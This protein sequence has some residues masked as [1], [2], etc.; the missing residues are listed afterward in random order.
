MVRISIADMVAATGARLLCGDASAQVHGITT[1][2]RAVEPGAVFV[3]FVGERV[4]G[5]R[6][7]AQAIEAG[8][9][10]VVLTEKPAME[11]PISPSAS[12]AAL[13]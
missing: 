4:N 12:M 11:M 5:N 13:R 6:F 3:C 2:S 10:A 9:G 8:A 1:D 7:A